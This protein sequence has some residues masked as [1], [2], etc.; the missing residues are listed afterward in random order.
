MLE[1]NLLTPPLLKILKAVNYTNNYVDGKP[2]VTVQFK[3]SRYGH[4]L[5][6]L[7][8]HD[9]EN[10]DHEKVFYLLNAKI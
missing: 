4:S 2:D 3:V 7:S 6:Y 9:Q 5:P 8:M 10:D 1:V